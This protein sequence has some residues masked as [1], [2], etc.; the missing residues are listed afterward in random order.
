MDDIWPAGD[1]DIFDDLGMSSME[2]GALLSD[3]DAY[4]D[5]QLLALARR[6]G[7]GEAFT[8]VVDVAAR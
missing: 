7:F 8:H 5:E 1:L 3:L 4:A 6:L 2:V